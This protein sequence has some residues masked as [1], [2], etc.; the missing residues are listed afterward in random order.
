MMRPVRGN[1]SATPIGRRSRLRAH[2]AHT[3]PEP[4]ASPVA[5]IRYTVGVALTSDEVPRISLAGLHRL[6]PCCRSS[7]YHDHKGMSDPLAASLTLRCSNCGRRVTRFLVENEDGVQIWPLPTDFQPIRVRVRF[8]SESRY[9]I[10][11]IRAKTE[12]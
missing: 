5:R 2:P 10:T 6:S 8:C 4:A 1:H 11:P 9:A 12:E 3:A 7:I